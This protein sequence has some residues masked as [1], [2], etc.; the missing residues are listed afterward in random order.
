MRL[1]KIEKKIADFG[2]TKTQETLDFIQYEKF[3]ESKNYKH[4]VTL[5]RHDNCIYWITSYGLS[6]ITS[7][8]LPNSNSSSIR[9]VPLIYG[10][11]D[12]FN[13]RLKAMIKTNLK[14]GRY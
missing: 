4:I 10:L 7:Y 14:R 12:L 3:C 5:E 9:P 13:K 11:N 1:K 2:F 8:G 6:F